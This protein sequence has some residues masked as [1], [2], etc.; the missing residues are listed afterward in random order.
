MDDFNETMAFGN[1]PDYSYGDDGILFDDESSSEYSI[2][3]LIFRILIC[4]FGVAGNALVI[5]VVL[6]LQE[7]KKT[8]T[9]W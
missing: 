8:I 9:H 6:V 1:D 3:I 7:Y 4:I 2:E 5:L